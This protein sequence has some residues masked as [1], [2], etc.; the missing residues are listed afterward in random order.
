[1]QFTRVS[2]AALYASVAGLA[3]AIAAP[4]AFAQVDEIVVSATKRQESLQEVAGA[5]TAVTA[6]SLERAGVEDLK[7]L[8]TLA[9]GL[10]LQQ[11]NSEVGSVS[12]RLRGIGT[13]GSN[14]G[15]ESSVGVFVDGIFLQRP[16]MALSDFLDIE[17]IEVLRGPQGTLF[18][19]NVSAGAIQVKS[20]RAN[21]EEFEMWALAE[22]G[23]Y[24]AWRFQGGVN[25]PVVEDVLGFRFAATARNQD[26]WFDRV[27]PG[28]ED[29]YERD[30][31]YMR[32]STHWN[33]SDAATLDISVDYGESDELCCDT[34]FL[35]DFNPDPP[36]GLVNPFV[37]GGA[38][39]ADFGDLIVGDDYES[40]ANKDFVN[41][42]E[43][44]GIT[45]ELQWELNGATLT[46]LT[47]YRDFTGDFS[48]GDGTSAGIF[49]L[50]SR[51]SSYTQ[52]LELSSWSHELRLQGVTG[53]LDW[54]VGGYFA[55][56]EL[57][58]LLNFGALPE[59]TIATGATFYDLLIPA[60]LFLSPADQAIFDAVPL[61]VGG[62]TLGDILSNGAAALLGGPAFDVPTAY[63]GGQSIDGLFS[64]AQA[65]QDSSSWSI[66]TH[67]TFD[68][69]DKLEFTFGL[70]WV[71]ES[72]DGTYNQIESGNPEFCT[73]T[74]ANAEA[75]STDAGLGGAIIADVLDGDADGNL[76]AT[77]GGAFPALAA[78]NCIM[79]L[80]PWG[81]ATTD[82]A[83]SL[84]IRNDPRFDLTFED[85]ELVYVASLNYFWTPEVSTYVKYAHGFK[86]GGFNFDST[87]TRGGSD[88]RFDSE[89][90]D[91]YEIGLRSDWLDGTLRVNLT[92]FYM[93]IEDFQQL[94]FDGFR[95]NTFNV[96][97]AESLGAELE[98]TWAPIDGLTIGEAL[99]YTDAG[100]PDD[101]VPAGDPA[102]ASIAALCGEDTVN[103][104]DWVSVTTAA[105]E[106]MLPNSDLMAFVSGNVR[107][108]S[109]RRASSLP[110]NFPTEIQDATT[111]LNARIGFG[112]ADESWTLELWGNNLTDEQAY[113][114]EY[115]S[116]LRRSPVLPADALSA[117][118]AAFGL[119]EPRTYGVTVR[120]RF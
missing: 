44:F 3:T 98:V 48:S 17:Q 69:T 95:F 84:G 112:A 72:K 53:R 103:S 59:Q 74:I 42:T 119:M 66:F 94:E 24:S 92:G 19:R 80:S 114:Q 86:S 89:K 56:E 22:A 82:S 39:D 68:V 37:A 30:R 52:P 12:I 46:Y 101:C 2:K 23:N 108:A 15:L 25:A 111:N 31:F 62:G 79:F 6:E 70:R 13:T 102:F 11:G 73:N 75:I 47:G 45:G 55:E 18:G 16:G 100:Y 49:E 14:V 27:T 97:K 32:A 60:Y 51:N 4:S 104:S 34:I 8:T 58:E 21:A 67:N 5:I 61:A 26:G 88:P 63:A 99:N 110:S 29:T 50:P 106:W 91:N 116:P 9:P 54:M 20:N 96:P 107:Y 71:D 33:I 76:V 1:M 41:K 90:V 64:V 115:A 10:V 113:T 28:E 77:I 43:Q 109:E 81:D 105:Y 65:Q 83:F 87:S 35:T 38:A 40:T 93:D 7:D 57:T 78:I 85:D 36:P 117:G 118:R 120:A